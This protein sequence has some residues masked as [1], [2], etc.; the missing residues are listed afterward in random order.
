MPPC[1][2]GLEI[3]PDQGN[4]EIKKERRKCGNA[5]IRWVEPSAGAAPATQQ[6]ETQHFYT[7]RY[8]RAGG[9]N[10]L[11]RSLKGS[12]LGL[13]TAGKK[14]EAA[15][16]SVCTRSSHSHLRQKK[17]LSIPSL[18]Q[19]G[20]DLASHGPEA[21]S[22]WHDCAHVNSVRSP[23]TWSALYTSTQGLLCSPQKAFSLWKDCDSFI[24]ETT[25]TAKV[26]QIL[27][28]E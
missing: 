24:T 21:F 10:C 25:A 13:C 9:V 23:G 19:T 20:K 11:G 3:W 16:A 28:T 12:S 4:E 5:G 7:L 15:V 18:A 14:K 26:Q 22:P 27:I 8:N 1:P 2:A 17:A 6:T